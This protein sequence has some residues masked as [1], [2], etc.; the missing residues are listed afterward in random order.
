MRAP[1]AKSTNIN[2]T[3]SPIHFKGPL[4]CCQVFD[5]TASTARSC[6]AGLVAVGSGAEVSGGF[7]VLNQTRRIGRLDACSLRRNR[8]HRS[9]PRSVPDGTGSRFAQVSHR[10]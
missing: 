4:R 7:A 6:T 8:L 1:I 10:R 5:S 3:V 9:A 2:P